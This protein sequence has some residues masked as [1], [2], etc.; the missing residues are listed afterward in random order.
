MRHLACSPPW[1]SRSQFPDDVTNSVSAQSTTVEQTERLGELEGMECEVGVR[2]PVP[3][4]RVR[5]LLRLQSGSVL[6]ASRLLTQ[7]LPLE[8][9]ACQVAWCEFEVVERRL[10]VRITELL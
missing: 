10:A 5:D 9:N 1:C 8:V 6:S 7:D 3:N 4:F 2:V